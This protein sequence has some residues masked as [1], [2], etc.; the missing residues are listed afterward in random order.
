[1]KR[2]SNAPVGFKSAI[3][4]L[5][6]IANKIDL[7][8]GNNF[9]TAPTELFSDSEVALIRNIAQDME[10]YANSGCA[11]C[12]DAEANLELTKN[13]LEISVREFDDLLT[14]HATATKDCRE[15][16]TRY[17]EL[18][19]VKI[20][21]A[22]TVHDLR[23]KLAADKKWTCFFCGEVF[24]DT[25][26]AAHHFGSKLHAEESYN[27]VANDRAEQA[28]AEVTRL[29]AL[30]PTQSDKDIDAAIRDQYHDLQQ[31]VLRLNDENNARRERWE[32]LKAW[33][34]LAQH[35]ISLD[36]MAELEAQR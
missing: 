4:P 5:L 6:E 33:H 24:I 2:P 16:Q 19:R 25:A 8:R 17:V 21:L 3:L 14:K 26:E 22:D 11:F 1:M 35:D 31:E 7:L 36:K 28:E 29:T 9:G 30:I 12:R 18:H 13:A 10:E 32:A 15:A 23:Q 34:L 27:N 20:H